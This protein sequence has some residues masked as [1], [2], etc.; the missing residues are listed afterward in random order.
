VSTV[1]RIV[2]EHQTLIVLAEDDYVALLALFGPLGREN[3]DEPDEVILLA[4][5]DA[6]RLATALVEAVERAKAAALK[7][8]NDS[9]QTQ[10]AAH[11][12][13]TARGDVR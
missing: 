13:E 7:A 11:T 8:R 9:M 5:N 6:E 2:G 4:V 12:G 1:K 10:V 3:I